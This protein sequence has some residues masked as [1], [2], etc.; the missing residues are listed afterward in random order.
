MLF[1]LLGQSLETRIAPEVL[2]NGVELSEVPPAVEFQGLHAGCKFPYRPFVITQDRECGCAFPA[3]PIFRPAYRFAVDLH[4]DRRDKVATALRLTRKYQGVP[5]H[6]C[7][8]AIPH[9]HP[10]TAEPSQRI[11]AFE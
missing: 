11:P 9:P 6:Q 2:V 8:A 7:K 1:L 10:G 5:I 3:E 4:H